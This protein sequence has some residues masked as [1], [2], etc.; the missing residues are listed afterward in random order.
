MTPTRITWTTAALLSA[1]ATAAG[2]KG[3]GG[4]DAP[5]GDPHV[6]DVEPNDVGDQAQVIQAP[7][8]VDGTTSGNAGLAEGNPDTD[9]FTFSPGSPGCYAM[10]LRGFGAA[11][12]NLGL[13]LGTRDET[14]EYPL[15]E[16]S[17]SESDENA[18]EAITRYLGGAS[19]LVMVQPW[20]TSESTSYALELAPSAPGTCVWPPYSVRAAVTG[21][22]ATGLRLRNGSE[23]VDVTMNGLFPFA[24]IADGTPYEV[25]ID[26]QPS[27]Q[28]CTIAN[29]RGT[30]WGADAIVYVA[31]SGGSPTYTVGGTVSGLAG[32]GLVLQD[33]ADGLEI[34]ANGEFTFPTARPDGSAYAVTVGYQPFGQ[35]CSV[36]SGSG[37]ISGAN[38]TD[39]SVT[40]TTSGGGGGGVIHGSCDYRAAD[41]D[42]ACVDFS[43]ASTDVLD[44]L[45]NGCTMPDQ[46]GDIG[47]WSA[48]PCPTAGRV[49]TCT[50]EMDE[51]VHHNRYYTEAAS[52][53]SEWC[54]FA[55][56][57][58][59]PS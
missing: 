39:V 25:T 26:T 49:G 4:G 16:F 34:S 48:E 12:L 20:A 42:A 52:S 29:G 59:T 3:E 47:T 6:A 55:N 53:G 37:T 19:Y 56:G 57:V 54:P 14:N 35:S 41:A 43:G 8:V 45:R 58:W 51:Y 40:C 50:W 18:T 33:G 17:G 1:L 10:T 5:R 38:V 23:Y 31:C 9:V 13:F 46:L 36:T 44:D 24:P 15:L 21:L 11:N 27:G 2:C 7:V 28:S 30:V 22:A 32:A